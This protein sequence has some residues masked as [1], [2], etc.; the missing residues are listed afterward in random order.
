MSDMNINWTKE[1]IHIQY[2]VVGCEKK[3]LK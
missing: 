1:L 3:N 2:M